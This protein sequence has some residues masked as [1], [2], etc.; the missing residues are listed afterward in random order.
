M[1]VV[2][3]II[4]PR[5][6]AGIKTCVAPSAVVDEKA[7]ESHA[8]SYAVVYDALAVKL[9]VAAEMVVVAGGDWNEHTVVVACR[10]FVCPPQCLTPPYEKYGLKMS[11]LDTAPACSGVTLWTLRPTA[12]AHAIARVTAVD[13]KMF[14]IIYFDN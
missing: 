3:A 4:T 5:A 2:E 12:K 14:L 11:G 13:T 7:V 9:A 6:F 1:L 10:M 8:H